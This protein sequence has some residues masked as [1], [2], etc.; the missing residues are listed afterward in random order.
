MRRYTAII[1]EATLTTAHQIAKLLAGLNPAGIVGVK[2][3]S[4]SQVAD[5]WDIRIARATAGGTTSVITSRKSEEGDAAPLAIVY[6]LTSDTEATALQYYDGE[7]GDP[8]GKYIFQRAPEDAFW[9]KPT[10]VFIV[11]SVIGVT[12]MTLRCVIE[13]VE[14]G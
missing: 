4:D 12:S 13:W 11:D 10:G 5:D 2:V 6:D 9:I 1:D 8:R 14:I 3:T 7:L